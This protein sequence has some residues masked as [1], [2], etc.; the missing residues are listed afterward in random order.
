MRPNLCHTIRVQITLAI[1]L[2]VSVAALGAMARDAH[3]AAPAAPYVL[4]A[5]NGPQ[6]SSPTAVAVD[7]SSGETYVADA[8][9]SA[10]ESYAADGSFL[11]S[12]GNTLVAS[13]GLSKPTGVAVDSSGEVYVADSGNNRIVEIGSDGFVHNSWGW[14][15]RDGSGQAETCHTSFDIVA[16]PGG[17]GGCLAGIAGSGDGQLSNPTALAI[18]PANG[19][20]YVADSDNERIEEFDGSG[21]YLGQ[22]HY[23]P[24]FLP[25]GLAFDPAGSNVYVADFNQNRVDEFS[26]SGTFVRQFG[27]GTVKNVPFGVAVDPST[28]NVYVSDFNTDRVQEFDSIGDYLGQLGSPG[29]A[30]GQLHT[31]LQLGFDSITGDV[32]VADEDNNRV[33][34]FDGT[35]PVCQP[36]GATTNFNTS[37]SVEPDCTDPGQQVQ[38]LQIASLPAHGSVS[39]QNG[40]FTYKPDAGYSG[41]DAFTFEVVGADTSA[42]ATVDIL[43]QAP[44]APTCQSQSESVAENAPS[45][46]SLNCPA[47]G[48]PVA[49]ELI[50]GPAHG[51]LGAIDPATG[52][53][54]YTPATGY[55]GADQIVFDATDATG[56]SAPATISLT[57]SPQPQSPNSQGSP[58]NPQPPS[59]PQLPAVGPQGVGTPHTPSAPTGSSSPVALRVVTCHSGSRVK[60]TCSVTFATGSWITSRANPVRYTVSRQGHK[61]LAGK[62][63]TRHGSFTLQSAKRLRPGRYVVSVI[64]NHNHQRIVLTRVVTVR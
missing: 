41:S 22:F 62:S 50:S 21:N 3:A 53:V 24:V 16:G 57:V 17:G 13:V 7:Q 44:P 37:V 43:V 56:V 47:S 9:N 55:T 19:N 1:A 49:Y 60:F 11:G 48:A 26:A 63:T 33:E 25:T 34:A 14:G 23:G 2:V 28:A 64:L 18:D 54:T 32:L 5:T 38:R 58:A 59:N 30:L 35:V 31:P 20:V 6:L 29:S 52:A 4:G 40:Q 36:A 8:N 61:V 51:T 27:G 42:P 10:I 15:V 12:F 45:T 39:L 46:L